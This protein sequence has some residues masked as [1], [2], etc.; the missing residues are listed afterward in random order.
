V[1]VLLTLPHS[2]QIAAAFMLGACFGSFANVLIHRLPRDESIA[3]PRSYCPRC[4]DTIPS[5]LNIPIVA[6]AVLRGRC[7]NCR[8]RISPRY[9]FVEALM[10]V[11]F[12]AL[13]LHNGPSGRLL[14]DFCVATA[15][16]AITFIDA[17]HQII[18]NAI[19]Y[20]GML[21][22][23]PCAWLVPPPTLL[24]AAIGMGVGG[25]MMWSV[26]SFYQ[27]RT[28]RLGLGFGDVK[29]IAMLGGFLGLQ[30]V[31]GVVVLG[32]LM[33]LVHGMVVIALR[34]G[35]RQTQIPFGP[36]L[37][38][39]GMFHLFEPELLPHLLAQP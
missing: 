35:G 31:L 14:I 8:A 13:L 11:L 28:G 21:V 39:A 1:S 2:V 36:A 7:R 22:A 10:G 17:E 20:P 18:P 4:G 19:T 12:V 16:V 15:L 26:A 30:G 5:L 24:N 6:Y 37:A 25:G 9:P 38:L 27:W 23:L 3:W 34:G 29:L 32:S 33:G